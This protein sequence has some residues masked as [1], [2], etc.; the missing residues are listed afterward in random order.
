MLSVIITNRRTLENSRENARS[1][2]DSRETARRRYGI[3]LSLR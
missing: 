2:A 1:F 3:S